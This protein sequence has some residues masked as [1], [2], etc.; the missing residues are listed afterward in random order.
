LLTFT[1]V[2]GFI[3][4]NFLL[5]GLVLDRQDY[6]AAGLQFT[7]AWHETY[8]KDISG[9]G[10]ETFSWI[11]D[12]CPSNNSYG[13]GGDGYPLTIRHRNTD[14][15]PK[16][17][18]ERRQPE[19]K[20]YSSLTGSPYISPS[21]TPTRAN[22]AATSTA[23]VLP[24]SAASQANFYAESGFFITTDSYDLRPEVMESYYYAYRITGDPKYQEWAWD[25][26]VAIN[27]TARVGSSF[28]SFVGVNDGPVQYGDNQESFFF[29]ELMK[30]AYLIFA[31]DGPWQVNCGGGS[32]NLF[33]YNTE[34][35]PFRAR[36]PPKLRK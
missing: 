13:S 29:A 30:Y 32:G 1:A 34:A 12:T 21:P 20:T 3:G 35:H 16:Q 26:F 15:L 11:P 24:A 17:E 4:G 27:A 5:G 10:P 19:R 18:R 23:C 22:N 2:A 6:I 7:A 31:E 28:S 25:A 14:P 9:I 33:V 36:N 8:A